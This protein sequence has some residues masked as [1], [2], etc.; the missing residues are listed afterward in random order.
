VAATSHTPSE[1]IQAIASPTTRAAPSGF[2]GRIAANS[3][4]ASQFAKHSAAAINDLASRRVGSYSTR[5]MVARRTER[6]TLAPPGRTNVPFGDVP[7]PAERWRID[8]RQRHLHGD[9]ERRPRRR[10]LGVCAN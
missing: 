4:D 2:H 1:A 5:K 9:P 7:Q 3:H 6:L 10:C 8:A